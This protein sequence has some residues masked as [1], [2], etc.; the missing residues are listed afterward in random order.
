MD[1][2]KCAAAMEIVEFDGVEIDRCTECGGM[3]FDQ[4]EKERL[5][6]AKGSESLDVGDPV[7]GAQHNR[8]GRVECPH[9]HTLMI[10]MVDVK[11]PHIW[12]EKCSICGGSYLDAGEFADLKDSSLSDFFKL[13][14][15]KP[16]T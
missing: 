13:F 9:C 11:Q 10:K 12:Y 6:E 7:V 8:Q 2:P 4:N 3:W 15:L 16:R 5:I 1:C 14:S